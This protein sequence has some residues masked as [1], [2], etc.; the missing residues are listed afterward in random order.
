MFLTGFDDSVVVRFGKLDLVRNTWR[1]FAYKIDS[2]GNYSPEVTNDFNV[3]A[4]NIEENDKRIP[5]PYR[6]P[7]D[8]QRVQTLSNNGV[9]LLQ[10]EQSLTLQF[11]G[12]NQ[13]DGKAV[14]QTFANRDLRQFGKLQMYIHAER[15]IETP[16]NDHDLMAVI[17]IG[18]DFVSNY[19]EVKI[20]LNLTPLNTGLNPDSKEYNDTLWIQ[21]NN[22]D[23]DL[24]ELTQI[25][26]SR[27]LSSSPLNALYSKLQ[28]NGQTYSIM[29]NPNLGEVTGI[30]MG[31]KN[32]GCRYCLR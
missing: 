6:T 18:S 13:N 2:T 30:L 3:G 22:L 32:T 19:Y 11:C 21:R 8:I 23:L 7:S 17:R 12:L 5:L 9:N 20:P 28:A 16:L 15:N 26:N 27:N 10:N 4:V 31:V 29:G 24:Y 25:K 1:K 14:F